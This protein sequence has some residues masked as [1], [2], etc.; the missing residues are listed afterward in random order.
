GI[1]AD[2]FGCE[3][4]TVNTTEGA[5]YGAALLAAVG[6]GEFPDVESACETAVKVTGSTLPDDK[7][8]KAYEAI[9]PLYRE[10]YP[11]LTSTF[12]KLGNS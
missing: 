2:V 3:L 9:Y 11:A 5:A 7:R 6:A 8:V 12:D 10:L 4:V 1:L